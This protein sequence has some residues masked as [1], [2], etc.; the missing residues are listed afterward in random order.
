MSWNSEYVR[1][2]NLNTDYSLSESEAHDEHERMA[3]RR[4]IPLRYELFR[5]AVI[6]A[7]LLVSIVFNIVMIG[8]R[9][10]SHSSRDQNLT[11]CEYQQI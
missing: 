5:P 3:T 10:L 6:K 9:I 11:Y 4:I 8:G 1:L 7:M 2:R